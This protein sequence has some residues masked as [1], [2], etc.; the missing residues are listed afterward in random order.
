MPI[1]TPPCSSLTLWHANVIIC[2][3]AHL[4]HTRRGL[5]GGGKENTTLQTE[6]PSDHIKK[7]AIQSGLKIN[8]QSTQARIDLRLPAKGVGDGGGGGGGGEMTGC[9]LPCQ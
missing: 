7:V 4:P 9:G 6:I 8:Q 5:E 1:A 2:T 3:P